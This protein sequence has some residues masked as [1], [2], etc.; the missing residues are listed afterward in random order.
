MIA[1]KGAP[2]WAPFLQT[3]GLLVIL[4]ATRHIGCSLVI[5]P[6]TEDFL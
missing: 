2:E 4:E 6:N 1:W 5:N 3:P